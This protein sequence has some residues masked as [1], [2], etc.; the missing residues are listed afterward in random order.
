MQNILKNQI[1]QIVSNPVIEPYFKEGLKIYNER[2]MVGNH[3]ELL[4]ADRLV[5]EGENVVIID[6]KTGKKDIKYLKITLLT[7]YFIL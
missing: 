1:L 5:F 7:D 6:Y 4:I 3:G 2:S